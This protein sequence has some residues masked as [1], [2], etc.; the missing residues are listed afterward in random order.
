MLDKTYPGPESIHRYVL[1]NGIV[2]LV[3]ENFAAESVV[4]DGLV[5]AGALGESAEKVGLSS[6]TAEMLLRGTEKRSFDEIYESIESIGANI[7]FSSG[8]HVTEFSTSSLAEDLDLML[9]LLAESLRRPT[10][11]TEQIEPVRGEVM[12][13]LHIRAND[14]RYQAGRAFRE[15]LYPNHPYGRSLDG[16]L[17]SVATITGEDLKDFHG[18]Y[19]GPEG[20][21]ITVV[22]AIKHEDALEKVKA[23]FGDW[24]PAP[25]Q[26]PELPSVELPAETLRT[27][28]DMPQKTQSDIMLGLPGPLRSAPDYLE[29]SMA[30]TVLGV[31]GM[32]GR[33][34]LTVREE[35]GLAYYA[36]SR[37]Q[38]GLG[39]APWYVSTGV[40][41]E[42]VQQAIDSILHEIDRIINEPIPE[43]ELADS[44]AYRSGTLPVSLETND[45]MATIITDI[46]LYQLGLDYLQKLPEKINAMTP[47]IVQAAAK[48][49]LSTEQIG[50][51]VAGPMKQA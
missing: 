31:F 45:G 50:I 29:A 36:Y 8:R 28:I 5:R 39:P 18:R 46:E 19:Y 49:Y 33:L 9:D 6:F 32:M 10:F 13:S 17:E 42:K 23:A 43:E 35:Q 47:E 14:T 11:P 2:L 24:Q 40:S 1:D 4:V 3:Y 21:I 25:E 26:L 30:N 12:A 27:H 34:G 37:L 7:D 41:P 15:L 38:G 51:A 44:Q 48:K 22:G 16:T 20:M